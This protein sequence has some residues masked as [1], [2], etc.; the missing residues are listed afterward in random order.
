MIYSH[1][2]SPI[3]ARVCEA[4][5]KEE[6]VVFEKLLGLLLS[7]LNVPVDKVTIHKEIISVKLESEDE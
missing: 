5:S 4:L 6:I 7:D 1:L 2:R 3:I